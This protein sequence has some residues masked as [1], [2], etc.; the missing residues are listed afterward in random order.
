M[1]RSPNANST[2][3]PSSALVDELMR[4]PENLEV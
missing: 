4:G 3:V 1:T 2:V